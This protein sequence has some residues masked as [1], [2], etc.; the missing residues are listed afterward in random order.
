MDLQTARL[1][2]LARSLFSLKASNPLP[3]LADE[4]IPVVVLEGPRVEHLAL[5]GELPFCAWTF[6]AGVAGENA[7]IQLHNPAGSRVQVVIEHITVF[8]GSASVT[9]IQ[10]SYQATAISAVAAI[11]SRQVRDTRVA[12]PLD[13]FPRGVVNFWTAGA[14]AIAAQLGDL[15]PA[16]PASGAQT[17]HRWEGGDIVLA[18]GM[19]VFIHNSLIA[20]GIQATWTWRERLLEASEAL[21]TR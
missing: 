10:L 2:D 16:I 12:K 15:V 6:R 14:A 5:S 1:T 7:T 3:G 9:V 11:H 20:A 17:W 13:P 21:A 18:P 4:V 8:S 19:G